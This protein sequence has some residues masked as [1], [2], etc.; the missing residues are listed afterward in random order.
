MKKRKNM[1]KRKKKKLK[2]S[3]S[4]FGDMRI[5]NAKFSCKFPNTVVF[6]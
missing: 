4:F 3:A 6:K 1:K 5:S 2:V